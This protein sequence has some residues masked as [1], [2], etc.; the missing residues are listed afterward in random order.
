[1]LRNSSKSSIC[2]IATILT[3]LLISGCDNT[4]PLLQNYDNSCEYSDLSEI[5]IMYKIPIAE[6]KIRRH[7][8]SS[9][10]GYKDKLN[11]Y[12]IN[13]SISD[14]SD[15]AAFSSKEVVKEHSRIIAHITISDNMYKTLLDTKIDSYSTYEVKDDA[16]FTSIISRDFTLDLLL[17]D[18]SHGISQVIIK[19]IED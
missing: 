16:P 13:V 15:V 1:M 7:L 10:R 17:K 9:L 8:I 14:E 6:H 19:T 4:R 2:G 5:K 11:K 12:K 18:I 3:A